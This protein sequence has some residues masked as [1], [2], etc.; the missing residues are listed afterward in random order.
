M[1]TLNIRR[2]RKEKFLTQEELAEKIGVTTQAISNY[3]TGRRRIP[4]SL[5]DPIREA[6]ECTWDELLGDDTN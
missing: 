5:L 3:E 2:L 1:L 4:V 6:L